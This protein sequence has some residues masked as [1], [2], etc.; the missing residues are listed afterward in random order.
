LIEPRIEY[1]DSLILR[2]QNGSA[3]TYLHSQ[4]ARANQDVLELD[5]FLPMVALNLA[6]AHYHSGRYDEA[7]S[8]LRETIAFEPNFVPAYL[9]LADWYR[10]EGREAQSAA[11]TSQALAIVERYEAMT[12]LTDYEAMLLGRPAPGG[13]GECGGQDGIAQTAGSGAGCDE[14]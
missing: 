14:N 9:R 1:A 5:P 6:E 3:G 12:A 11:L 7:V 2:L 8:R 4:I 10:I 13:D